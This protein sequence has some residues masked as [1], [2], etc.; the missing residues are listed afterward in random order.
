M[1]RTLSQPAT[2]PICARG[3]GPQ[4]PPGPQGYCP[5]R[6]LIRAMHRDD[7]YTKFGIPKY[8]IQLPGNSVRGPGWRGGAAD[9]AHGVAG[10]VAQAGTLR[11]AAAELPGPRT[12]ATGR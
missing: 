9:V 1:F 5:Q 11:A 7:S 3:S 8:G 6:F 10:G 12:A 2:Q 4:R